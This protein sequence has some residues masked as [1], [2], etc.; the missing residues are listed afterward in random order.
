MPNITL[1]VPAEV[2]TKAKVRAA[3]SGTSVSGLV[4]DFLV[5]L[6]NSAD[7]DRLKQLE[8]DARARIAE[9]RRPFSAADRLSRDEL[10]DRAARRREADNERL[11]GL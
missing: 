9:S 11:Q 2:L 10:Y 5:S 4:R 7:Y 6:E 3:M 1:T 8:V